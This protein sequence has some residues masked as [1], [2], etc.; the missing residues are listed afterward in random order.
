MNACSCRNL[1]PDS[2]CFRRG[3]G[4]P[5]Q[6]RDFGPKV[7]STHV[8]TNPRRPAP[9]LPVPIA[10]GRLF[11][12]ASWFVRP[13]ASTCYRKYFNNSL[14]LLLCPRTSRPETCANIRTY[15]KFENIGGPCHDILAA[16]CQRPGAVSPPIE[17][18]YVAFTRYVAK[19]SHRLISDPSLCMPTLR[20]RYTYLTVLPVL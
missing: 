7:R 11:S 6:N 13:I 5:D 12:S 20:V 15:S 4:P 17:A 9:T 2:F 19:R 18:L 3:S 10:G 1:A 16:E 14:A 8:Q